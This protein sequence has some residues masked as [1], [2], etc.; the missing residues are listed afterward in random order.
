MV[1][2]LGR[3]M[4]L[5]NNAD[6]HK[7]LK[8]DL[9]QYEEKDEFFTIEEGSELAKNFMVAHN[10]AA[11]HGF[12]NRALLQTKIEEAVEKT[13]GWKKNLPV[14]YDMSHISIMKEKHFDKNVWVHRNGSVRAFGPERMR[15]VKIYEETGEPIFVPSSMSTPAYLGAATDENESTFFS[16]PH[17]TGKAKDKTSEVPENRKQLIEKMQKRKVRLY[18][19]S[20]KGIIHQDA[21]HYK[22]IEPAIEGMKENKVM[23]PVAK[24]RPIA[25]LMA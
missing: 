17:G 19:G 12:A 5:K 16:A 11:N 20:S 4:F 8:Y 9:P 6:W 24:M 21:S 3:K 22:N 2:G 7:R 15:G 18:N 23:K 14:V 1:Y 25:V 10:A 13:L